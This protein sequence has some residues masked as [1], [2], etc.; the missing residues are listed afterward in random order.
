V[1]RAVDEGFRLR[2]WVHDFYPGAH[3]LSKPE[4]AMAPAFLFGREKLGFVAAAGVVSA[5]ICTMTYLS[6]IAAQLFARLPS[7][8]PKTGRFPLD[9]PCGTS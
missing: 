4:F 2:C 7:N 9:P 1:Q 5:E 6:A 3:Q 8:V